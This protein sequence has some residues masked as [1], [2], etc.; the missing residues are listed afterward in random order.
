M[1]KKKTFTRAILVIIC[2]LTLIFT[3]SCAEKVQ[4]GDNTE[5]S[6]QFLTAVME[7]DYNTAYGLLK[8]TVSKADF[9]TFWNTLRY[10]SSEAKSYTAKQIGWQ[11]RVDKGATVR[12]SAYQVNFDNGKIILL[13]VTTHE[14]IEGIAGIYF[15]DTTD[16]TNRTDRFVPALKVVFTALSVLSIAFIIWMFV[17]CLRRKIRNKAVWAIIVWA[18]ISL[19]FTIGQQS[20]FKLLFGFMLKTSS[21]V[22]DPA[23]ES[24]IARIALPLGAILYFFLRKKLAVKENAPART[25]LEGPAPDTTDTSDGATK[26]EDVEGKAE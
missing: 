11:L 16:F 20:G 2:V 7:N 13:R 15:S 26:T 22:A 14:E 5:L 21:I 12:V 3:S 23:I 8:N 19:T 24:V 6:D 1:R 25:E 18:G 17:D 9:D 10:V 4:I